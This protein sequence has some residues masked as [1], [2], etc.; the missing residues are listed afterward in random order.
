VIEFAIL[1]HGTVTGMRLV[2]TSG[3]VTLDRAAW[4]SITSS[5]PYPPLPTK[6][7][8][9]FLGLRFTFYYNPDKADV[10]GDPTNPTDQSSSKSGIKVSISPTDGGKVPIGGFEVV[11]AT[12]TGS[13]NAAVKWRVTGMGCSGSTCG[14]MSADMY[15]APKVLPSP[16]SVVLTATSEADPTASASVR[17]QLVPPDPPR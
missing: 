3:D 10:A 6:F 2:S 13:T 9:K 17:V 7:G 11:D 1:K 4:G 8:D 15:L 12:V 5:N 16:P 14:I